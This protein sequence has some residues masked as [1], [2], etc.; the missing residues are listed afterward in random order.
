MKNINLNKNNPLSNQPINIPQNNQIRPNP[1]N[2]QIIQN[3]P[4]NNIEQEKQLLT[5]ENQNITN[6]DENKNNNEE[7]NENINDNINKEISGILSSK[8]EEIQKRPLT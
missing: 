5:K 8:K 1:I 3:S 7:K 6:K 4:Q 2:K